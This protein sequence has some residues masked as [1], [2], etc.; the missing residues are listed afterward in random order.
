MIYVASWFEITNGLN[1]A[2]EFYEIIVDP[3]SP[4]TLY[5]ATQGDG[6]FISH[7]GGVHW[8]PWNAY[9]RR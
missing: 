8:A 5:L 3:V 2:Q 4:D 6:V 1:V 9:S 7:D